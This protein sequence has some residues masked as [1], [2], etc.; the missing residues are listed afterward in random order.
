MDKTSYYVISIEKDG[1]LFAYV[2]RVH[3]R[4]NLWAI[5]SDISEECSVSTVNACDT[6]R[7]ALDIANTWV[8][9]YRANGC[10]MRNP[11]IASHVVWG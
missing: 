4:E 9:N 2:L 5:L 7:E 6:K 11:P 8:G 3:H 10:L 1:D